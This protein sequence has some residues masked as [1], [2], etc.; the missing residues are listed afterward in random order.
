MPSQPPKIAKWLALIGRHFR[1]RLLGGLLLIVPV[2]I[3]F[4]I[5]KAIFDFLDPLLKDF[6]DQFITVYPGMG[7]VALVIVVYLAGILATQVVG[8]RIIDL[9]INVVDRIPVVSGVYRAARQATDVFS[10]V[11]GNGRYSSVVLVEFPGYGL[12]SVGLVTG[13]IKDQKGN[14]LLAVY[15]PTSPFP[16]SGFL[17]ILPEDQV[18]PTDLA[19]D[20]AIKMIVTAGVVVPDSIDADYY[21]FQHAPSVARRA[22][23]VGVTMEETQSADNVSSNQ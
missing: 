1:T 12:T 5:L 10:N 16:T 21:P 19:V 9:G 11:A 7:I 6:M 17:I 8:K 23:P 15:M 3:T 14:D 4:L 18:T 20:D 13:K 2:G 22:S